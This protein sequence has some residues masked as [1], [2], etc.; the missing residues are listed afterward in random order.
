MSDVPAAHCLALDVS[1][2]LGSALNAKLFIKL[3]P[4]ERKP[5]CENLG[6]HNHVEKT[7]LQIEESSATPMMRLGQSSVRCATIQSCLGESSSEI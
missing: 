1:D 3:S 5:A 2:A 4:D 6:F 7:R